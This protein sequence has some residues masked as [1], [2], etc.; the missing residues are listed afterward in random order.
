M[1]TV[2]RLASNKLGNKVC[3]VTIPST[4]KLVGQRQEQDNLHVRLL[5]INLVYLFDT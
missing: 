2:L 3:V 1:S 5:L 4:L